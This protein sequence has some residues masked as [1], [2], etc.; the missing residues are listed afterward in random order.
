ML[1]IHREQKDREP[2]GTVGPHG[3]AMAFLV[4]LAFHV[5]LL[6][7]LACCIYTAGKPSQGLLIAADIGESTETSLDLTQTFELKPTYQDAET[8][9]PEDD[10]SIDVNLD[11][12]LDAPVDAGQS[13]GSEALTATLTSVSGADIVRSLQPA[14]DGKGA[15]F[16]GA[17]AEGNRFVYVL[18]SS[19]SMLGNRWT[20]ACNQ[21]MDSLAGLKPGQEFLVI[22]FDAE[23]TFQFNLPPQRASYY[24]SN[25]AIRLK[26]RRWLRSRNLGRAT[27]P[28]E[29]LQYALNFKP[30][31]IFLLSD[32]ELQ[33]N[34][35]G[36]LRIVNGFSSERRQT[37]VHTVHLMSLQGRMTLQ[38][39]ALENSGTF[40]P[41]EGNRGFGVLRNR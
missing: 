33:D 5:S 20:Y 17:Y 13:D 23:T 34:S 9:A 27:M 36:M 26:V 18:D 28:G 11:S 2:K 29:A 41:I 4:S 39:I 31:A 37:P 7:L 12:L 38:Q 22:C 1:E 35:I 10:F 21:L 8:D 15:S 40:T 14:G 16:F 32:G 6:L 24:E 25:D 19:R 3:N 30:D